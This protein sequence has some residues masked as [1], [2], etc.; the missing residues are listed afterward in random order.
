M[1]SLVQFSYRCSVGFHRRFLIQGLCLVIGISAIGLG[2]SRAQDAATGPIGRIEGNDVSVEGGTAGSRPATA[3]PNILVSNGSIVTVHSGQAHLTLATGG[4]VDICGPAKMT[5]LQSGTS[6]TLAVNFGYVRVRLPA[7]ADLRVFTPTIVATPI[8]I[9]GAARDVTIGL[10][11]DDSLC[12]SATSGA[13]Q[14]EH[15]FTGEKLIVP[16]L[17]E[18][19]LSEGK[20]VPVATTSGGC[21]CSAIPAQVQPQSRIAS[22]SSP[23]IPEFGGVVPPETMPTPQPPSRSAQ[24]VTE[25]NVEFSIAARSN[26][27]HPVP[28]S[29][30]I[31]QAPPSVPVYTVVAPPLIFSSSSPAPPPDPSPDVI[32]L[33]REARVDP[34][35]EFAGH[36]DPPAFAKALQHA[37]GQDG[38]AAPQPSEEPTKRNHGF[39]ARLKSVF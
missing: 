8:N 25:P 37:L 34:E 14:L 27:D 22:S 21:R 13:L 23:V 36:V 19:S 3:A 18:F 5:L 24:P 39:W 15:Q 17:G 2:L 35:Y 28:R 32:L 38:P 33:V 16:Q 29:S 26:E 1:Y 12:V 7:S 11:L 30:P 4:E 10:D 20:L 6:L 9:G 31:S